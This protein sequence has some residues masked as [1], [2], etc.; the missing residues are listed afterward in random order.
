MKKI[1]LIVAV[2][3]NWVIGKRGELPWKLPA[4]LKHFKVLTIGHSV[5]MGRKTFDSIGKPLVDRTNIVLSAKDGLNIP[6]CIVAKSAQEALE[7]SPEDREIFVIGG[8]R[9]YNQFLPLVQTI[10]LTKIYHELEGDIFFPKLDFSEW[11]EVWREDFKSDSKNPYDY[12]FVTLEKT[13]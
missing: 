1:S 13:R 2:D 7:L 10:Y 4:D 9:I 5:I 11:R 12:S 6:G 3:K 8:G